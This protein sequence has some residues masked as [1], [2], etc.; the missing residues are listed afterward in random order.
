[1]KTD[2]NLKNAGLEYSVP[3]I[4]ITTLVALMHLGYFERGMQVDWTDGKDGRA[5]CR[6]WQK[7]RLV[8]LYS[9]WIDV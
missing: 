6:E 7:N 4:I 1:M 5:I 2:G 8:V 9:F 3:S